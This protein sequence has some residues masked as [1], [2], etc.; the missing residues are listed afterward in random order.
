MIKIAMIAP[1]GENIRCGIR[2]YSEALI[3]ALAELGVEIYVVRLP[4]FG[5]KTPELLQQV[6][7][8]VPVDK[9]DLIH[10]QEEYGLYQNLEGGFYGGLKQLG[11]P[12]V[13]TLHAVG[14][15]DVDHVICSASTRVI[16]H[17]E[18]CAKRLGQFSYIIPHGC[19]MEKCVPAEEAK[20]ALG[21]DPRIPVV[22][23]LGFISNYKGLENLIE[24]MTHVPRAALLI[25]GD[26]HVATDTPYINELKQRSLQ[27]LPNRC[28]WLGY[29]D[30]E[31]LPTVYGAME[32]VVYPSRWSTESGALLM[33]LSHG[34]AVVASNVAPFR[35][36]EKLGA[37]VTFRDVPDLARKIRRLLRDGEARRVLEEGAWSY[38][39][40]NSW[41]EVAR[42][43][44]SLYEDILAKVE[45]VE[46]EEAHHREG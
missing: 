19:A 30:D 42:K 46:R 1:W 4:R 31:R 25:G 14:N 43:T 39:E 11:K 28:Q 37:L 34:K 15:W 6:V 45:G 26:W 5:Q 7:D 2:T 23:Y 41:A 29:V 38:A 27:L 18:S 44:L 8:S 20:K 13:T 24:A 9:V 12:V 17:N 21:I 33:A 22:G 3:E 40:A 35:E 32:L 16:L 10:V 36:K